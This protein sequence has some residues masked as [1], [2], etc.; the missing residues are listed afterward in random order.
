MESEINQDI[1]AKMRA[2][3]SR[4]SNPSQALNSD[5]E[6]KGKKMVNTHQN[7]EKRKIHRRKAGAS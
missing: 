7:L 6:V 5:L 1:K 4:K 3:L 2:A